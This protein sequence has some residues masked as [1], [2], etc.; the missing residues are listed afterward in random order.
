VYGWCGRRR[1]TGGTP[2]TQRTKARHG[3]ATVLKFSGGFEQ[4]RTHFHATTREG[5]VLLP[6]D[7]RSLYERRSHLVCCRSLRDCSVR[8]HCDGRRTHRSTGRGRL[9]LNSG[10]APSAEAPPIPGGDL[11]AERIRDESPA[12]EHPLGSHCARSCQ[13]QGCR[14]RGLKNLQRAP[15]VNHRGSGVFR[16]SLPGHRRKRPADPRDGAAR[17]TGPGRREYAGSED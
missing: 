7:A 6:G 17:R 14:W 9:A 15:R 5:Q 1:P 10:G 13:R 16:G 12:A 4:R 2:S 8:D 3:S 11:S